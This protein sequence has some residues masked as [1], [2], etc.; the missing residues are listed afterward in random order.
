MQ[1]KVQLIQ[2]LFEISVGIQS[3]Y[4]VDTESSQ[5][6]FNLSC[7]VQDFEQF[8]FRRTSIQSTRDLQVQDISEHEKNGTRTI[9]RRTL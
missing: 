9:F 5:A 2:K 1:R 4:I 6:T 3:F 7:F 8:R